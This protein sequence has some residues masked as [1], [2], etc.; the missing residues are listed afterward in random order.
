MFRHLSTSDGQRQS[1]ANVSSAIGELGYRGISIG[2]H[3][4]DL[5]I[6]W[7]GLNAY[8]LPRQ[9]VKFLHRRW[10]LLAPRS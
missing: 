4:C 7:A 2:A 3:N 8:S 10:L 9:T 6:F 1:V 5:E